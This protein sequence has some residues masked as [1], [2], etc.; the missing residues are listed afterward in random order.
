[1]HVAVMPKEKLCEHTIKN[2]IGGNIQY[3]SCCSFVCIRIIAVV[4][5]LIITSN[6]QQC[7]D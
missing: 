3:A 4:I 6:T 5:L 2:N 1:M 7:K